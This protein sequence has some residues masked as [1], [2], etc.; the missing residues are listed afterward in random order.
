[1]AVSVAKLSW[2]L[3]RT[4]TGRLTFFA[5]FSPKTRKLQ[6]LWLRSPMCELMSV[7]LQ[8]PP[9]H[10]RKIISSL[11][12]HPSLLTRKAH[13]YDSKRITPPSKLTSTTETAKNNVHEAANNRFA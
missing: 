9:E 11:H 2:S 3:S 6:R 4:N 10:M 12:L 13:R 8:N 7:S 5:A 1:M